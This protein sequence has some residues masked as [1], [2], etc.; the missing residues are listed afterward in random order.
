MVLWILVL[1]LTLAAVLVAFLPTFTADKS[2]DPSVSSSDFDNDI[3]VYRDQLREL[4]AELA[5]GQISEPDA[6]Q[7][8]AEIARRLLQV[9]Q[10]QKSAAHS[11]NFGNTNKFGRFAIT[12]VALVFVPI[13]SLIIYSSVGSP[14]VEAQPLAA[15]LAEIRTIQAA[16]QQNEIQLRDLVARA[17]SHLRQNPEDGRGWEVLAPI[18]LRLGA[19]ESAAKAYENSIR[20]LGDSAERLSGLAE[21]KV[22]FADGF[23]SAESVALFQKSISIDAAN[24]RSQYYLAIGLAQSGHAQEAVQRLSAIALN[25][26]AEGDWRIAAA[27]AA[28]QI[29]QEFRGANA[30]DTLQSDAPAIDGETIEQLS[31]LPADERKDLIAGMVSQLADRLKTEGGS[32]GEWQRLIRSYFVLN[33]RDNAKSAILEALLEYEG[34]QGARQQLLNFSKE[35]GLKVDSEATN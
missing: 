31:S 16:Q 12:S 34:N 3:L 33:Q 11:S 6:K 4:E 25:E 26:Q 29:S 19:F 35:L 13:F 18:Y 20:L 9:E 24:H 1:A 2:T 14:S 15:R 10:R 32:V 17:E 7:A 5:R 28:A 22:M 23:V 27:N 30:S 21:A 8:H